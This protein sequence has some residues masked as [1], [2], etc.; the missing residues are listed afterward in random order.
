MIN[1]ISYLNILLHSRKE[2]LTCLNLEQNKIKRAY[3]IHNVH[4]VQI[5]R[6]YK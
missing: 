1:G 6:L 4:N 2:L 3:N 5:K